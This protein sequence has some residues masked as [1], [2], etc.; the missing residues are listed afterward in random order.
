MDSIK[1]KQDLKMYI[2]V[3]DVFPDYMT[4][5]LVAHAVLNAHMKFIGNNKDYMKW[6]QHSF[7]KVVVKVSQKE[8]DK[9][10]ELENVFI[11]SENNTLGGKPSC[12]VVCPREDNPN[13]LKYAKLWAPKKVTD[14]VNEETSSI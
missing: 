10:A 3:L 13:V 6:L 14:G 9:I 7:R 12:I 1:P 11:G 8:F 2:A 4:P 5:T